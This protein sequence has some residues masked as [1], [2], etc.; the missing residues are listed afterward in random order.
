MRRV[1]LT[2]PKSMELWYEEWRP[3]YARGLHLLLQTEPVLVAPVPLLH[4]GGHR[5]LVQPGG[6]LTLS[7]WSRR[8]RRGLLVVVMRTSVLRHSRVSVSIVV[9][10]I[11]KT[12]VWNYVNVYTGST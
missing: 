3:G 1:V 9:V 4:V 2:T 12:Y 10:H 8:S 5:Q 7:M 6:L 11:T